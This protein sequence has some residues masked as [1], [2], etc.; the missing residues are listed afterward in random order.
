MANVQ[1]KVDDHLRNEAQAVAAS[2]GID[3]ASAVRMFLTQMVREKGLPFRPCVDPFHSAKNQAHSARIVD[4]LNNG[5]NCATYALSED[6]DSALRLFLHFLI[7]DISRYP[8]RIQAVDGGTVQYL[9]S[10]VSDVEVDLDSALP[11]D[12]E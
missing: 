2:M 7:G 10:L 9:A 5:R 12:E 6:D 1:V 4:D 8:E 11:M 3:L